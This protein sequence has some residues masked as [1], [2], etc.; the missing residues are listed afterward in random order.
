[1]KIKK[2]D[3][4]KVLLGKDSGKEATVAFVL[5]KDKKVFV[6]GINLYKRHV[7]RMQDM[8]GG[9]VNLP[10]PIDVS[11]VALVCPNCKK[12]TRVGFKKDGDVKLRVCKKC[13]K[14]IK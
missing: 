4:V 5:A 3:K 8:E 7:K 1:M 11:N 6:E 14:D 2:G 12:L 13:G 9:I 10:K